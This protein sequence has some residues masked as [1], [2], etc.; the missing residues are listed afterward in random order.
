MFEVLP[1]VVVAAGN[2]EVTRS[3]VVRMA[4]C[5]SFVNDEDNEE[6][7]ED[8]DDDE[9]AVVVD[10]LERNEVL[11]E[12]FTSLGEETALSLLLLPLLLVLLSSA[13]VLLS[14]EV[15]EVLLV[16]TS[17]FSQLAPDIV[18]VTVAV[19]VVAAAIWVLFNVGTT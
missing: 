17:F 8:D 10:A 15:S 3:S 12:L 13:L 11:K 4:S 2:A 7:E 1:S 16:E 14:I 19:A 18:V 9:V 6:E 5:A